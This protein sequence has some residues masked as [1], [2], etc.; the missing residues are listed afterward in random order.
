[1]HFSIFQQIQE[2]LLEL[3]SFTAQPS[4]SMYYVL[5]PGD[6]MQGPFMSWPTQPGTI[7]RP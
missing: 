6:K 3:L 2:T 7:C 4:V 5:N 1:M